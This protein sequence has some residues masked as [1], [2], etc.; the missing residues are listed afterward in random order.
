MFALSSPPFL[1]ENVSVSIPA[2]CVGDHSLISHRQESHK[3]KWRLHPCLLPPLN[4]L[5]PPSLYV[6]PRFP[7]HCLLMH[8]HTSAVPKH[9]HTYAHTHS[10]PPFLQT[11]A[12]RLLVLLVSVGVSFEM[13]LYTSAPELT[14]IGLNSFNSHDICLLA[15][16]LSKQAQAQL[17]SWETVTLAFVCVREGNVIAC[18]KNT[19]WRNIQFE[20][21]HRYGLTHLTPLHKLISDL[22]L[23]SESSHILG[24]FLMCYCSFAAVCS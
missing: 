6:I 12:N 22:D 5:F 23:C 8:I 4:P 11:D 2:A 16:L 19:L 18:A 1:E 7:S 21:T 10:S 17:A 24:C 15:Y 3:A 9:T 20:Y 14:S 13:N